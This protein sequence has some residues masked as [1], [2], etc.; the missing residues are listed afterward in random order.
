L[1][2]HQTKIIGN[3]SFVFE[4]FFFFFFPG[5]YDTFLSNLCIL[6][7]RAKRV[8]RANSVNILPNNTLSREGTNGERSPYSSFYAYPS[9]L[10]KRPGHNLGTFFE[11]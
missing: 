8:D 5:S 10:R 3:Y 4:S 6:E 11:S 2:T 1:R 9:E 7:E